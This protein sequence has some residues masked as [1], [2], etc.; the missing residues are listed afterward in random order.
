[1]PLDEREDARFQKAVFGA[2][3]QISARL[4]KAA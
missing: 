2:Q 3:N 1:L 4:K